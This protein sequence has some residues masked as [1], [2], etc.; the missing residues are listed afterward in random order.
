MASQFAPMFM[1]TVAAFS[2]WSGYSLVLK[3]NL[4]SPALSAAILLLKLR[5][6]GRNGARAAPARG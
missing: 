5:Y 4:V 1:L 2:L 6:R 3:S